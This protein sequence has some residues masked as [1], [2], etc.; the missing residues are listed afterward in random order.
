MLNVLPFSFLVPG[1]RERR[2]SSRHTA[3]S[4]AYQPALLLA[5]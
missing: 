2:M 3:S 5:Y 4:D 1:K